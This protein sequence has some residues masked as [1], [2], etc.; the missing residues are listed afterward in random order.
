MLLKKILFAIAWKKI[1]GQQDGSVGKALAAKPNTLSSMQETHTA[2][3]KKINSHKLSSDIHMCAMAQA[4]IH[5][6]S[7]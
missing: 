4:C 6:I 5:T 7:Q 1:Q 3:E 2:K